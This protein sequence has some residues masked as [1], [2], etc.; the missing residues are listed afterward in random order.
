MRRLTGLGRGRR[1]AKINV[2]KIL[3]RVPNESS[4]LLP[5]G[6]SSSTRVADLVSLR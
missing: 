4:P 6:R 3:Y 2:G 5:R 1:R